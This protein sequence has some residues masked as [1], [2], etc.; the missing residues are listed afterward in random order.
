VT[1]GYARSDQLDELLACAA[2]LA[3]KTLI[4]DVEPL[5]APWDSGQEPLDR[6]L[7]RFLGQVRQIPSVRVVVFSTNSARRPSAIPPGDGIEV[8]YLASA[9]KPLRT[10]PY[11]DLPRPGA[12]LGDQLPTDG[13]LAHRLG[14]VFLHYVP[15]LASV[16][17]GPRLMHGWGQV[18]RPVLFRRPACPP[19][20]RSPGPALSTGPYRR[21]LP[22][23]ATAR[24]GRGSVTGGPG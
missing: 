15:D 9:G 6:G 7:A 3:V 8:R 16:P 23:G 18:L 2:R 20:D 19:D 10:A 17:V 11:D 12:V 22:T 5:V 24:S 4:V 13:L 21:A 1:S 14:Y